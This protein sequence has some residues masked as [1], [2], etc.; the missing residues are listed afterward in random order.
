MDSK[1]IVGSEILSQ[2]LV[3]PSFSEPDYAKTLSSIGEGIFLGCST[4]LGMPFFLNVTTAINPH[5]FI[6]GMS[7]SGKTY[8]TKNLMLKM[9]LLLEYS[10]VLIDFTGEYRE[11]AEFVGY[12]CGA[13][14]ELMKLLES[15][16]G[17]LIY[18]NLA[19]MKD[20]EKIAIGTSLIDE[21]TLHMRQRGTKDESRLFIVLDEA[22]KLLLESDA[23]SII[24]REGRK[25]HTGLILASQLIE[26]IEL[27]ILGNIASILIFRIQNKESL[28]KIEKN[29]QLETEQISLIQ[30]LPIGACFFIQLKKA[31]LREAF[32]IS[33]ISGFTPPSIIRLNQGANMVDIE[34]NKLERIIRKIAHS[35][36]SVLLAKLSSEREISAEMLVTELIK[37]KADRL[38]I[39]SSLR[40]VG[41]KEKS[42]A[43]AFAASVNRS[44]EDEK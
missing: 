14:N 24:V 15:S 30:N 6:A 22:W 28:A 27:S 32:A 12:L 5:I 10:V 44:I 26:D 37:L 21:L 42:L 38:A 8:L 2:L 35:D 43:D 25:Y 3:F 41:L 18:F 20:N 13:T 19:N 4:R 17:Q 39:L 11:F 16:K 34:Y 33:H 23:L 7:G 40:H 36:P 9:C 29:Y 1:L 31:G